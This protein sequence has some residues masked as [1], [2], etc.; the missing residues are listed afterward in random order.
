MTRILPRR[1]YYTL[2]SGKNSKLKYFI[3]SILRT[4]TPRCMLRPFL[5][6]KLDRL[7]TR[8]DKDYII[9][10][11]N[12]YCKLSDATPYD[13]RVWRAESVALNEQAITSPKV[14]YYDAMRYARWFDGHLRWV[15]VARDLSCNMKIPSIVKSRLIGEGNECSVLLKLNAV[16]HFIFVNDRKRWDDKKDMA[17]FRGGLGKGRRMRIRKSFVG[18]Y[19]DNPMFDIGVSDR[20]CPEWH[21]PKMTI[22]EHLDYKF[23]MSLEGNDVASNLKWVMSSNSI[24]VMPRPECETWF[25]EGRLIPD[26]HY[27]EVKSDFSDVEEK[28]RYYFSH[29][30]LAHEIIRHAHEWVDQFRD[31]RRETLISL[32]V[33]DKYFRITNG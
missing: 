2:N 5:H 3:A 24:A 23:I 7:A 28:L 11:V 9:D 27:I 8:S 22:A 6:R 19:W 30:D 16:R 18:K 25:M 17:V 12:Y 21:K 29:P 4:N 10:R 14:Y 31:T 33:L 15:L 20:Q 32:L 26:Y 13:K 1:I